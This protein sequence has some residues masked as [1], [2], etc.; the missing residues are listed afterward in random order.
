MTYNPFPSA[1]QKEDE[2]R[3]VEYSGE[4]I[5]IEMLLNYLLS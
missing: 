2:V 4:E 3:T 1:M 5:I